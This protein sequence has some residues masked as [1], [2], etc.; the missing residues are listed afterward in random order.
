[1]KRL[2]KK[3]AR[4]FRFSLVGTTTFTVQILLTILM[5]E[6]IHIV[7]YVSYA[8]AL[9]IAWVI[10]FLLNRII[11]FKVVDN[12][13]K[14]FTRFII[15]SIS[16]NVLNW[17]LVLFFVENL[18]VYYIM[19]IVFVTATIAIANFCVQ[20]AWVYKKIKT[21]ENTIPSKHLE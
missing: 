7:Y 18:H 14:R 13:I 2:F 16:V 15:V 20:E 3:A 4:F 19:A 21:A 6:M 10:N 8:I 5:T 12:G 1:M 9:A 11:T 17:L